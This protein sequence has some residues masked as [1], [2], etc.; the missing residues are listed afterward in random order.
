LL[1]TSHRS[2]QTG[3]QYPD[4]CADDQSDYQADPKVHS[5]RDLTIHIANRQPTRLPDHGV[6]A[7]W[8]LAK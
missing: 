1:V 3:N 5:S 8:S 6:F 4:V 7:E 2:K